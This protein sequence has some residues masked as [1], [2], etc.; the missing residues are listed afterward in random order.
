MTLGGVGENVLDHGVGKRASLASI[1]SVDAAANLQSDQFEFGFCNFI[2]AAIIGTSTEL[3]R[4]L[5][6]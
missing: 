5:P 3:T 4:Q 2:H 6:K 1:G